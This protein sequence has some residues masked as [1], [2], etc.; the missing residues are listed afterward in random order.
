MIISLVLLTALF[1]IQARMP[2]VLVTW[3]HCWLIFSQASTRAPRSISSSSPRPAALPG[4]V[5]DK[6]KDPA[7]GLVALYSIGLSPAIQPVQI[8]LQG[9][10]TAFP[11]NYF[12]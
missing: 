12:H 6:V 8:P 1:L 9:M 4:V 2:L 11:S 10:T 7:L 3:A 5:V